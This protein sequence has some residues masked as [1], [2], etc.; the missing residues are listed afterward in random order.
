L[1]FWEYFQKNQTT[2]SIFTKLH[3]MHQIS[4]IV[5]FLTLKGVVY[6]NLDP[7]NLYIKKGLIVKCTD[8][9]NAYHSEINMLKYSKGHCSRKTILPYISNF[10]SNINFSYG[11]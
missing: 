3:L 7:K 4:L 6:H 9:S 5:R 8:L 11:D 10:E 1:V 2:I